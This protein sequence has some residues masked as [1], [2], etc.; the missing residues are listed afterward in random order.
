MKIRIIPSEVAI[1][2]FLKKFVIAL[3]LL[4]IVGFV[5]IYLITNGK[6]FM[7]S[8]D[9]IGNTAGNIINGGLF[10]EKDGFIYFSNPNDDGSLYV[11]NSTGTQFRKLHND[12]AVFINV[13]EHYIYY[14][15]SN[16]TKKSQHGSF[17]MFNNT[18]L[19]KVDQNGKNLKVIS[20]KPGSHITLK[21][22][23]LYY[24]NYDVEEGLYLY[25][26]KIDR[27]EEMVL[28]KDAV[29]PT[30][31]DDGRL[32]YA[33][34]TKNHNLNS[35]DLSSYTTRTEVKGNIMYPIYHGQYIY[36]ID[37]DDNYA[38]KRMKTDG[39]KSTTLVKDRVFT[40]N[41]SNSGQYLYYQIDN[42]KNNQLARLNLENLES[43]T[44]IEGD[45]KQI[46]VT[47]NYVFFTAFDNSETYSQLA[48]GKINVVTFNPPNLS[49]EA[50]K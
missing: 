17:L 6:T 43:E 18:G 20:N 11:M 40:Y 26:Q 29:I 25:R 10:S 16:H 8:D 38:L 42:A 48:D 45:F 13:D 46:H 21:G 31:I 35:L 15:R 27:T 41:I 14:L 34:N 24:Q 4:T 7:N 44:V 50:K 5:G 3:I 49:V 23:Y 33:G 22:N 28:V 39:S 47:D 37:M 1:V 36:Y 30:L 9:E 2:S 12:K 19:Y 32:Y